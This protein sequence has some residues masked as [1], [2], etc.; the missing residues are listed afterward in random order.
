MDSAVLDTNRESNMNEQ[1]TQVKKNLLT[2]ARVSTLAAKEF[3]ALER[4]Q[5]TISGYQ[6]AIAELT[7]PTPTDPTAEAEQE[8]RG[9]DTYRAA[10]WLSADKQADVSLSNSTPWRY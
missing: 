5:A 8:E 7:Q 2:R 6:A 1:A 9:G 4:H 3:A 10:Y